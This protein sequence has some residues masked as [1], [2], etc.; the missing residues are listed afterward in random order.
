MLRHLG[1]LAAGLLAGP[2]A[3]HAGTIWGTNGHEYEVVTSEGVTWTSANAAAQS[4]GWY[5]ATIGSAAENSFVKS[6]LNPGLA[7]RSHFWL[8]ATDQA[9]EGTFV[10]VDGTPFSFTDWWSGEP[11]N[12]NNED[13]LAMDLHAG[14]WAWNDAPDNLGTLY[15]FA[16]GYL[17]E[18]DSR[19]PT[20]PEPGSL[21][22]LGLAVMGLSRRRKA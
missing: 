13:F 6:L 4:S 22:L 19:T 12:A 17:L 15:G 2:M 8:G 20:V 9:I 11:N 7:A 5:L 21:A 14:T 10:W 18:R 1:L 3:A 16:R